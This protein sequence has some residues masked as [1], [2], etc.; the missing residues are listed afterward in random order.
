MNVYVYDEMADALLPRAVG[1]SAGLLEHFFRGRLDVTVT[2]DDVNDP[3]TGAPDP[4][5]RQ[6]AGVNASDDTLG[7]GSIWIFAEDLATRER[8]AV[9]F[10]SADGAASAAIGATPKGAPIRDLAGRPIRFR[11]PFATERYVVAYAGD[12]GAE[13]RTG[14]AIGA[15]AGKVIGGE[16]VEAIVSDGDRRLLRTPEALVPLPAAADRLHTFQ[17]GDLDNTFV[18]LVSLV[19][20]ELRPDRVRAFRIARERGA[21]TIPRVPRPD[22][23]AEAA[24]D[25]VKAVDF[26]YGLSLDTVV[27]WS[28][29]KRFQQT[30][31][32]YDLA[33]TFTFD[34]VDAD[35][36]TIYRLSQVQVGAPA[37]EVVVARTEPFAQSFGLVLDEAHLLR[38]GIAPR[39]YAWR[40]AEVGLDARERLLALVEVHL[41]VPD[42]SLR[43]VGLVGLDRDCRLGPRETV[44]LVARFPVGHLLSALIDVETG[45]VLGTTATRLIEPRT[46]EDEGA[47]LL[48]QRFVQ[49]F[50]GGPLEGIRTSCFET[51]GTLEDPRFGI[52]DRGTLHQPPVGIAA[53]GVPGWYRADLDALVTT[54][55]WPVTAT[56]TSRLV[57]HVD[58]ENGVN[59][60]VQIA[61]PVS[62]VQGYLT[63][64]RE[65]LRM[66]PAATDTSEILLRFARP[67]GARPEEGEEALLVRWSPGSPAQSR[68]AYPDELA[69]A[70]YALRSAT[71]EAALLRADDGSGNVASLLVE[72][73]PA[74]ARTYPQRDLAE[75]FV[76]L[77][78]ELLYN[79]DDTRFYTL[80]L[81]QTA[82]PLPLADGP[83]SPPSTSAFHVLTPAP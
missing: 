78:P 9:S 69:P 60:A 62:S 67:V 28:H 74:R 43:T 80:A 30:L 35:G 40:V 21:A 38:P 22:G 39:P 36:N 11:P 75:D 20:G 15:V 10:V 63:H 6:L 2:L 32:T 5:I 64:V 42:D 24:V 46:T 18:G 1:Y 53:L 12:L 13:R 7:P 16:R 77:A 50:V 82:L 51:A 70:L 8:A 17:W 26:P 31:V 79:V 29:V 65:G 44:P 14:E 45:R 76:L 83:A 55:V 56:V 49:T 61:T 68:L 27:D 57:Y 19:P 47:S 59:H 4:T 41:T 25:V 34:G 52:Q 81:E 37:S 48:Q 54:S 71:P 73:E 33:E 66:R 72:F 58:I 23:G 3:D